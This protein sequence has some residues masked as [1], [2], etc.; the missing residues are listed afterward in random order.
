MARH[1]FG[2]RPYRYLG[3]VAVAPAGVPEC[4]A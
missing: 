3:T 1:R 2:D 4:F